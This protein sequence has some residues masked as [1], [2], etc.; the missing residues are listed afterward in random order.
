VEG[1]KDG[2]RRFHLQVE[3]KREKGGSRLFPSVV[4]EGRKQSKKKSLERIATWRQ[5]PDER[6]KKKRGGERPPP[7]R[8]ERGKEK[9]DLEGEKERLQPS[10][11]AEAS[12]H[13]RKK[14]SSSI[15]TSAKKRRGREAQEKG[16]QS[17]VNQKKKRSCSIS[18]LPGALKKEKKGRGKKIFFFPITQDLEKRGG[19]PGDAS[20]LLPG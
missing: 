12:C 19:V 1:K 5:A 6:K 18:M 7:I 8:P 9:G 20:T 11:L 14:K 4:G 17:T 10:S 16:A 2:L 13:D 3:E 15:S